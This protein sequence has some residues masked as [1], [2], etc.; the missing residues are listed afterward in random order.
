MPDTPNPE[1][2]IQ[3]V[4]DKVITVTTEVNP[5]TIIVEEGKTGVSAYQDA[6]A[7][8]FVGTVQDWLASLHGANG[9]NGAD[10]AA[11][12]IV[13][14]QA[15][16]GEPGTP[17]IV[18]NVG[19]TTNA[20]L[21]FKIPR[22]ADGIQ[23][24][25]GK[26]GKDGLTTSVNGVQQVNGAITLTPADIGADVAG[27]AATAQSNAI[28]TSESYTD[29]KISAEVTRANAAYDPAGAATTALNA[30][31]SYTDSSILDEVSRANQAYDAKGAAT[32]AQANAISTSES[33]TDGKISAEVTRANSAYDAAGA[34]ATA[35]SNAISTSEA[36][37][38][39]NFI[40]LTQ[41]AA[42]N[43]VAT[44]DSTGKVPNSQLPPLAITDT[45]VVNSQAA[46][47]ALSAQVGDV[48]VRTDVSKSFI[49]KAS[50]ATTLANWQEL[51]TPPNAVLSVDGRVGAV[52]LTDLYDASGAA[53]TAQS[54]AISTSESYTDGKISAEVTRA[55]AAYD[56]SGAAATAQANANSYTDGKISAEVTRA[57][58]AYDASGAAATAQSNAISTSESYTDG[59][60]SAEVT[61]ANAAYDASGAAATAQS[62]ANGYTDGKISAEVTRANAAYDASGAATTALNSAKSYTDAKSVSATAPITASGTLG[63]GVTIGINKIVDADISSSAA[64][65][66]S[67]LAN[68][69]VTVDGQSVALG[70]SINVLPTDGAA[71]YILAKN[72]ATNFD[73]A[74]V[75][76]A[77]AQVEEVVKNQTGGL[78]TKGTVVYITGATGANVLVGKAQANA[79]STSFQTY[80]F[81]K[82][83]IA[84]GSTGYVIV[85][86]VI[87]GI[88][89][90]DAG[91]EGDPVYL[92]PTVAGGVVYGLANEPYAPSHLVYLGVVTR[93]HANQGAIAINIRDSYELDELHDVNI[94]HTNPIAD[95]DVLS[96]S[97][98]TGLWYNVAN[99]VKKTVA[100][101]WSAAQTFFTNVATDVPVT[102]KAAS[103]QS[104][105]LLNITDN[106]NVS[107]FS[108][109]SAGYVTAGNIQT[110]SGVRIGSAV[111]Y[112]TNKNWLAVQNTGTAPTG[113]VTS[114]GILYTTGGELHYLSG[115]GADSQLSP[116]ITTATYTTASIAD[117]GT[118]AGTIT[119]AQGYR[120]LSIQ[121]SVAARVRLY[122]TT[123]GRDN[124]SEIVRGFGIDPVTSIGCML[125]FKTAVGTLTSDL[126][127]LAEGYVASGTAIPIR[128]DN[129]SGSTAAI[130]VTLTYVRTI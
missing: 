45:F 108:V 110:N 85:S 123:T 125:D 61:R 27:A 63:T 121:T 120:I 20:I 77:T 17:V 130:T 116:T 53:A 5:T 15:E 111:T 114:G 32:T 38:D 67:K 9:A 65:A 58:A 56:A 97:S 26:D 124:G 1:I 19:S 101:I 18:T 48:A 128:V 2:T 35:Q 74:W 54:N 33:Y 30:S 12:Q 88:D 22:G 105:N 10:G 71:G 89:T 44:L 83:D 119:I 129:V 42:N 47:L 113:S 46:M 36:Y 90:S 95:G 14:T 93:K 109:G 60:I 23:G 62:N 73:L 75:E 16:T 37:A 66:N 6:V 87:S 96:Y 68:S 25:D 57:N 4:N 34:A 107:L 106:S 55:N 41:K 94:N 40:P 43:G 29:G 64:I 98:S 7:N 86:G 115:V 50:P 91:N 122:T 3:V 81:L 102:I 59:K 28:S 70:G 118:S 39:A 127:P 11:G 100:N 84:N 104:A 24:K 49:L 76:N 80:G 79:E 31:K 72:S 82:T 13:G 117:G 8:G 52:S 112:T 21:D 92:S 103:G 78:L 126:S 69:S 99:Y 51:L